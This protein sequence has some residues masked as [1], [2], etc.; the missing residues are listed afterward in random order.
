MCDLTKMFME[1]ASND[2]LL[3]FFAVPDFLLAVRKGK[4]PVPCTSLGLLLLVLPSV[5]IS[6]GPECPHSVI[7]LLPGT[8]YEII[9]DWG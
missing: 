7:D 4:N 6:L 3:N 8:I 9:Q 2:W 1:Y 5:W